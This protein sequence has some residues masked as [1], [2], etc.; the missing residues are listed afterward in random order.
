MSGD[1][2]A[3]LVGV[4]AGRRLVVLTGAGCSTESGIPDY[5][6]PQTRA[7]TRN[8]IQYRA[9]VTDPAA[10]Q[11]YWSRS[12]AG[13]PRLDAARP[14]PAHHALAELEARG[15]VVGLI[16][17]NV[18][19]LH[20]RAGSRAVVE[21]HGAIED[22]RCLGCGVLVPRAAFQAELLA[23]NPDALWRAIEVAPDGDAATADDTRAFVVPPCRACGG[24]MKPDVVFFG[25]SV[26]AARVAAADA[27]LAGAD[28]LLVVGTSLAVYSALRV[29]RAA[30]AADRPCAL[31]N[32]GPPERGAEHFALHVDAPAGQAL[33]A[34]AASLS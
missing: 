1:G 3:D 24:V 21:L 4:L 22:V 27:L 5:R 15:R 12:L 23:A 32:L 30:R 25:E 16:T 34:L 28:A 6:G 8:P 10:R 9:F 19:R 13:W 20:T 33:R 17:Q 26:P 29:V 11:R 2:L 18:D 7:R 14:N 31:V